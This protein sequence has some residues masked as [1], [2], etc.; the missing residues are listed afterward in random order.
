MTQC[1]ILKHL[2]YYPSIFV[3][4]ITLVPKLDG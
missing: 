4:A 2:S 1:V 3:P